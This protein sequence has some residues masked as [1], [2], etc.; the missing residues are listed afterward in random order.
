VGGEREPNGTRDWLL[1]R[2]AS[3]LARIDQ[4]L[5]AIEATLAKT[6]SPGE[7]LKAVIGLLLPLLVL[8]LTGNVEAARKLIGL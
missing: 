5:T 4:R 3:D 6:V 1:H 8:L 7:W 2:I